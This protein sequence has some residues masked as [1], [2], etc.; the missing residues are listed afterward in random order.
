MKKMGPVVEQLLKKYDLWQGYLQ[1]LVV[2]KWA[3]I[4]GP[5]LCSVT[6]ADSISRGKL[7][8]LVK[9]SVWAYHLTM[10]KPQLI[11]KLN[12]EAGVVVVKDIYFSINPVDHDP[13]QEE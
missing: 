3:D 2:E 9:D 5:P 11:S 6:K 13:K 8:V 4:V 12:K 10:L 1:F 7:K